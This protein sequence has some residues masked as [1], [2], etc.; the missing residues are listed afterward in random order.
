MKR[1]FKT[2]GIFLS[3]IFLLTAC[4]SSNDEVKEEELIEKDYDS[5]KDYNGV[6]VLLQLLS[7]DGIAVKTFK[8]GENIYFTLVITNNSKETLYLPDYSIFIGKEAFKVFSSDGKTLGVPY[9]SYAISGPTAI[10]SGDVLTIKCPWLDDQ[11]VTNPIVVNNPNHESGISFAK[12]TSRPMIPKGSY[13]T[14]F[15][16]TLNDDQKIVCRKDFKVI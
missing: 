11:S 16:I 15:T 8:K 7:E 12:L 10:S 2:L 1:T 13:Y 4:S 9:D 6:H 14:E 5:G 3:A